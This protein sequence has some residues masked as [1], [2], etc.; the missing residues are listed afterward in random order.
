MEKRFSEVKGRI[1]KTAEFGPWEDVTRQSLTIYRGVVNEILFE[2]LVPLEN[3][4]DYYDSVIDGGIR[5]VALFGVQNV[6]KLREWNLIKI[7]AHIVRCRKEL[8]EKKMKAAKELGGLIQ[9]MYSGQQQQ[10]MKQLAA[11]SIGVLMNTVSEDSRY[12]ITS[13]SNEQEAA[14]ALARLRSDLNQHIYSQPYRETLRTYGKPGA[15]TRYWPFLV[16][17]VVGVFKVIGNWQG[18]VAW[19]KDQVVETAAS[20]WSN[21]IVEPI[22]K[23]YQTIRHDENAQV[24]IMTKQSLHSDMESLERMVVQFCKD[25]SPQINEQELV[26]SV[27]QGD[28]SAVL[29]PYEKDIQKP[30]KSLITGNLVQALLIQVQKTKVDVEVAM[31]GIDKLLQSQQL[32]FGLVAALPS[33]AFL[34]WFSGQAVQVAKGKGRQLRGK[35]RLKKRIALNLGIIEQIL[36]SNGRDEPLDAVRLGLVVART[37]FL[38]SDARQLL[39]SGDIYR[40]FCH[41]LDGLDN[42]ELPVSDHLEAL[43][44]IYL[45]RS[46]S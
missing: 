18:I 10:D 15:T 40:Q 8:Y 22:W 43:K 6:F 16:F 31:N 3:S 32:V 35:S 30:F 25:L 28:I 23:I 33:L 37:Q 45:A 27:Q 24:A 14:N 42:P 21:W 12:G 44:W 29:I 36:K 46:A 19:F 38:R 7:R 26:K 5:G 9:Q 2:T 20:M 4:V 1:G 17:G 41:R 13:V 39:G 11:Q 34:W